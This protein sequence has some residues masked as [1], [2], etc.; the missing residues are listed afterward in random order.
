MT[1]SLLQTLESKYRSHE[2]T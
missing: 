2:V 1:L